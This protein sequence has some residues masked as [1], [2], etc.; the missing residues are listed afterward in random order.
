MSEF[1]LTTHADHNPLIVALREVGVDVRRVEWKAPLPDLER[2]I[3]FY[4]NLFD[5][6]K[7]WSGL[8]RLA[9]KLRASSVP[10]VFWNRDAPWNTGIKHRNLWALK[11][12][13]PIDIYLAHSLQNKEWFGSE[14]H[15]FPNAAQQTYYKETDLQALRDESSYDYDVSYFGSFG[16]RKDRNARLRA[17][18]LDRLRHQL[19]HSRPDLRV[20]TIDT[21][22]T[23]LTLNEQINLIRSSKI[24][25]N[26]GAMCDLPGAPSWGL[27][28]RVFGIPGAGGLVISD[29]RKHLPETFPGNSIPTFDSPEACSKLI[30]RLLLDWAEMRRMAEKQHLQVVTRHTYQQRAHFLMKLLAA[31]CPMAKVSP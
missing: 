11:I 24:N 21:A 27:P 14:T 13:K 20:L 6:I 2:C 19:R 7:D 12:I 17:E 23:P 9:R 26:I 31:Y 22:K 5:E 29:A 10:Y 18:F 3:A 28:E 25:L 16:N 8:L 15:Y 1:I 30:L 4:G